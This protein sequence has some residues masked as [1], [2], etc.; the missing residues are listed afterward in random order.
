MQKNSLSF[1][2]MHDASAY[3]TWCAGLH[4]TGRSD[5]GA[6]EDADGVTASLA[7]RVPLGLCDSKSNVR[8][9]ISFQVAILEPSKWA[10]FSKPYPHENRW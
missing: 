1:V 9:A 4:S 6:E 5:E 8:S 3:N 2:E 7:R 10:I